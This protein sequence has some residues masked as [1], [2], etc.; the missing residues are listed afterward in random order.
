MADNEETE[1]EGTDDFEATYGAAAGDASESDENA[2]GAEATSDRKALLRQLAEGDDA[3][4]KLASEA[5]VA[6][7]E[8]EAK[9]AREAE[10]LAAAE[11]VG[12]VSLASLMADYERARYDPEADPAAVA[13]LGQQVEAVKDALRQQALAQREAQ[14]EAADAFGEAEMRRYLTAEGFADEEVERQI[15][16]WR[17]GVADTAA[18]HAGSDPLED[19]EVWQEYQAQQHEQAKLREVLY[20]MKAERLDYFDQLGAEA[21]EANEAFIDRL[22]SE[23]VA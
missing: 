4:S 1:N 22:V 14:R 8:R 20:Q 10:L 17:Q 15:A 18:F 2:A 16:E 13:K 11:D 12:P 9:A 6:L 23:G 19:S 7:E 21:S 3:F 5:L